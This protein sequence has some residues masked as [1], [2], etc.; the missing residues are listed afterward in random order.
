[1]KK[2]TVFIEGDSKELTF[3]EPILII[4]EDPYILVKKA[5]VFWDYDSIITENNELT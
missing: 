2:I 4:N 1:M 5:T 3:D